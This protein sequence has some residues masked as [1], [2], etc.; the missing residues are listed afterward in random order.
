MKNVLVMGAGGMGCLF[1]G[2]LQRNA[3]AHVM[4]LDVWAEHVDI[5]NR[6]GLTIVEPSAVPVAIPVKAVSDARSIP[7]QWPD[8][9]LIFVKS[10]DTASAARSISECCRSDTLVVTL[11]NGLGNVEAIRDA[12]PNHPVAVGT[13]NQGAYVAKPGHIVHSAF[14]ET[15]LGG[16]D[17]ALVEDVAALLRRA[18]FKTACH[19]NI[20][21]IIWTKVAVNAAYNSLTALTRLKNGVLAEYTDALA[22]QSLVVDEV[23]QVAQRLGVRFNSPDINRYVLDLVKDIG[24]ARSSMLQDILRHRRTEIDA[25]NGAVSRLGLALGVNTPVN[26]VLTHLVHIIEQSY[27][28][29]EPM[30]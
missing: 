8:V 9:V 22:L 14:G 19:P 1:G 18:G 25:I 4:L 11:Q 24:A 21:T 3:A 26:D 12:L 30:D 17:A 7:R 5:L 20:D 10:F 29:Q 15:H 2:Y 13:T 28:R 16:E 6:R 23:S 27:T